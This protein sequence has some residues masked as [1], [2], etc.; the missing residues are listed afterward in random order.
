MKRCY[1]SCSG[2]GNWVGGR[3][4]TVYPFVLLKCVVKEYTKLNWQAKHGKTILLYCLW[5]HTCGQ[6][7]H[8]IQERE[9]GEREET[10]LGGATLGFS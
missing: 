1:I 6:G 4:F 10:D 5:I 7:K 3:H 9:G 8:H 2:D